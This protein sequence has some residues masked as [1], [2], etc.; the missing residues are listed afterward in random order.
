MR[1][2]KVILGLA[3]SAAGLV[4]CKQN[5]FIMEC[6]HPHYK[7]ISTAMPRLECDPS[8]SVTPSIAAIPRPSR[9]DDPDR[10]LRFLTL[11][12]SFAL[13]LENGTTGLQSILNPGNANPLSVNFGRSGP[14]QGSDSIRVFSLD[15]AI[16]GAGM[17]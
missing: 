10:K 6:D 16:V 13:A 15:P 7:D 17:E 1:W 5:C 14:V 8:M 12:E 9:V 11:Q 3:L 4:G 2:K